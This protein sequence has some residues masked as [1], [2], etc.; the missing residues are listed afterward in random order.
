MNM[1]LSDI[2]SA[3]DQIVESQRNAHRE[4]VSP[5]NAFVHFGDLNQKWIKLHDELRTL[6]DALREI[7]GVDE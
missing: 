6:A 7:R 1:N 4:T 5:H 2:Q 3:L